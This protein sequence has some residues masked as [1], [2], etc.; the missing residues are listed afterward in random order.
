MILEVS[1]AIHSKQNILIIFG[2]KHELSLDDLDDN[3]HD[4]NHLQEEYLWHDV[5]DRS[6]IQEDAYTRT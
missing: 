6:K 5:C 2:K 1:Y 4:T 3:V